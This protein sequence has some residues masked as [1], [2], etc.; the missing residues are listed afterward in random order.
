MEKRGANVRQR[1]ARGRRGAQET[2]CPRRTGRSSRWAP[3]IAFRSHPCFPLSSSF[4]SSSASGNAAGAPGGNGGRP[5]CPAL[6]AA[7][8][9]RA[10]ARGGCVGAAFRHI[11]ASPRPRSRTI[12]KP[13]EPGPCY[14]LFLSAGCSPPA[15][16]PVFPVR[17]EPSR[18]SSAAAAVPA[19]GAGEEVPP[20]GA[21]EVAGL[22]LQGEGSGRAMPARKLGGR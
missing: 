16:S 17:A 11:P 14:L 12:E 22:R 2:A 7:R 19:R 6:P 21:A 20:P 5:S 9:P 3:A 13:V 18:G 8:P 10:A 15:S 4:P 1:P